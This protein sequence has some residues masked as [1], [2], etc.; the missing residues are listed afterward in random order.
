MPEISI[1]LTERQRFFDNA[2]PAR[3][4]IIKPIFLWD[5]V[6]TRRPCGAFVGVIY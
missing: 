4:K 1:A 3:R 6:V 5:W 2:N